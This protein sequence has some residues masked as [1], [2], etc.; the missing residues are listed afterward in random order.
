MAFMRKTAWTQRVN[1]Y[2]KG[3]RI[4]IREKTPLV[5]ANGAFSWKS[6]KQKSH[7][8]EATTKRPDIWP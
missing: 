5:S 4:C 6:P 7:R 8:S 2:S 1:I 3:Q